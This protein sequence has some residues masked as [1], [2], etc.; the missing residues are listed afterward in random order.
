MPVD[1]SFLP[2][3]LIVLILAIAFADHT[4]R[5]A[6]EEALRAAQ[7]E[8]TRIARLTTVGAMAA[9]IAHEISQPLASIVANGNA[10]LR[11]LIRSEPN[12]EEARSAFE[13][14]VKEGHRAGE[15][16]GGIRAMF[17]K[18]STKRAPV[19]V[20]EFVCDVIATSLGEIKRRNISLALQLFDDLPLVHADRVQL[21]Q[22]L[23]NLITNA[24]DSMSSMNNS[25]RV[26]SA[27]RA[28]G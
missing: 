28:S 16:I 5:L 8:L 24:I 18:E 26:W 7:N 22:V 25:P 12:Q 13:R 27:L 3:W 11:W 10:G 23:A 1:R 6:A 17:R 4:A 21:Q 2:A 19:V 15:I 20:N 9:S 14:I